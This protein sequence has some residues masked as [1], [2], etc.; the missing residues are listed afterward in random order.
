MLYKEFTYYDV[1][2]I[3]KNTSKTDIKLQIGISYLKF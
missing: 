3:K 1:I 2:I